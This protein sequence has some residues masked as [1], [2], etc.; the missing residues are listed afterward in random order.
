MKEHLRDENGQ[1]TLYRT[2]PLSRADAQQVANWL[3][4]KMGEMSLELA[5]QA[6]LDIPSG[7][8]VG[9]NGN[10]LSSIFRQ[11]ELKIQPNI[12]VFVP[13]IARLISGKDKLT[14]DE[15]VAAEALHI[16][17]IYAFKDLAIRHYFMIYG[18]PSGPP[19]LW[20][21]GCCV[22]CPI[23]LLCKPPHRGSNKYRC[24]PLRLRRDCSLPWIIP[25]KE[26][27]GMDDGLFEKSCRSLG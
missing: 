27:L 16:R 24:F 9:D 12:P 10:L 8:L 22:G 21:S 19:Q 25:L 6:A 26:Y 1:Y 15:T 5:L 17:I 20:A 4:A 18:D 11:K 2:L 3:K 23:S 14:P 7:N 13:A